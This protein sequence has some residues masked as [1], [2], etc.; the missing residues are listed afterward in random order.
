MALRWRSAWLLALV[1]GVLQQ[2]TCAEEE[3][4]SDDAAEEMSEEEAEA[5]V[6]ADVEVL[7]SKLQGMS[8][9]LR[10][11]AGTGD[12][13]AL[14]TIK[15]L[16]DAC[17]E[18]LSQAAKM[19]TTLEKYEVLAEALSKRDEWLAALTKTQAD[20]Q[21]RH[22]KEEQAEDFQRAMRDEV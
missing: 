21:K 6:A 9:A 15:G 19:D 18:A 16:A 4:A 11:A 5:A 1:F 20:T 2:L 14:A 12:T 7:K 13:P 3:G 10:A 22:K 17:D 8:G